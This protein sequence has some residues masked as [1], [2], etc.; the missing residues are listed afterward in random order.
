MLNKKVIQQLFKSTKQEVLKS[1]SEKQPDLVG[2]ID[3][4]SVPQ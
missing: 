1:V 3:S 2:I 4:S